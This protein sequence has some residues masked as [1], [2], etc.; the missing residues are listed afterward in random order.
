MKKTILVLIM[1][2]IPILAISYCESHYTRYNCEVIKVQDNCIK[3]YD[4][5]TDTAW[6]FYADGLKVGDKVDLQMHTNNTT[7][8]YDDKVQD[9]KV[10]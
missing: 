10:R 3:A 4:N 9:I 8:I 1:I 2:I 7:Q 5:V 6:E